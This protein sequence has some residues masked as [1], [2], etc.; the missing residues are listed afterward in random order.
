MFPSPLLSDSKCPLLALDNYTLNV[1]RRNLSGFALG[2]GGSGQTLPR[3]SSRF[4]VADSSVTQTGTECSKM[5]LPA[6]LCNPTT[7]FTVAS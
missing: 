5:V 4:L 7:D 2:L 6:V 3:M 1:L